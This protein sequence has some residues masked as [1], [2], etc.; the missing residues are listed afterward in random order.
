MRKSLVY[1][2]LLLSLASGCASPLINP[3]VP[4]LP[5]RAAMPSMFEPQ[6][7][8]EYRIQVGDKLAVRSY[9]DQQ[10]NQDVFVRRDGRVSLLLLQDI[11]VLN[12]TTAELGEYLSLE[13]AKRVDAQSVTVAVTESAALSVYVGGEVQVSSQQPLT[14][15]LTVTQ[16][17]T[18]AGGFRPSANTHQVLVLRRQQDG[19]FVA[20]QLDIEKVLVNTASDVYLQRYDI[21]HVPMSKVAHVGKFVDQYINQIVPEALRFNGNYTW[22]DDVSSGGTNRGVQVVTP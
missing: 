7:E 21:V 10:L 19:R 15:P 11:E 18:A 1:P 14:G 12:R 2:V 8:Q 6:V 4:G 20:Y 3:L 16:A 13:Y 5:D 17:I 22:I 9:Y